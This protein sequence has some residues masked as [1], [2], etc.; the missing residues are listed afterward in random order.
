MIYVLKMSAPLP[1]KKPKSTKM[2]ETK[3]PKMPSKTSRE[4]GGWV[5]QKDGK[6]K[7]VKGPGRYVA[8]N[9]GSGKLIWKPGKRWKSA[10][11]HPVYGNLRY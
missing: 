7:W 4:E 2:A 3:M 6:F 11:E 1:T 8:K 9:D 10:N 5:E